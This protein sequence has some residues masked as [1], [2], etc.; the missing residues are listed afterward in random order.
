MRKDSI[1]LLGSLGGN[2]ASGITGKGNTLGY[3]CLIGSLPR[4]KDLSNGQTEIEDHRVCGKDPSVRIPAPSSQDGDHPAV[5][6]RRENLSRK[7][8]GSPRACGKD[9]DGQPWGGELGH[10]GEEWLNEKGWITPRRE[11]PTSA[12][13]DIFGDHPR[14]RERLSL[15]R[16]QLRY[17][18][19]GSR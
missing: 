7:I 11:R 1:G 9:A 2:P 8:G 3:V 13:L 15:I 10:S 16:H 18:G 19:W 6:E 5:R 12:N 14:V 17:P 4:G